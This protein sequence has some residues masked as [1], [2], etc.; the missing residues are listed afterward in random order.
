MHLGGV[1]VL[2]LAGYT[3]LMQAAQQG[4]SA[5]VKELLSAGADLE[6]VSEK[7]RDTALTLACASGRLEVVR[8][9]IARGAQVEHRNANDYTPLC[10]AALNAHDDDAARLE[11]IRELASHGADINA[12]T[13]TKLGASCE[14]FP[15][16]LLSPHPAFPPLSSLV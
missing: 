3:A 1:S 14:P 16:R 11:I 15:L 13:N 5:V 8:L 12:R 10:C 7:G 9:L 6:V 4:H 2:F